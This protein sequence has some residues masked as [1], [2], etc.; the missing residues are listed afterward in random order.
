M[1]IYYAICHA[2]LHYDIN[3]DKVLAKRLG[4]SQQVNADAQGD[5]NVSPYKFIA[6]PPLQLRDH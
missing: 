2:D 1:T 6:N 3:R 4:Y 5:Q